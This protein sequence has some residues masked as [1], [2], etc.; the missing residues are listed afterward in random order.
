LELDSSITHSS[1]N[2]RRDVNILV[3]NQ[4]GETMQVWS[5]L[6]AVPVG[7]KTPSLKADSNTVALEELVLAYEGLRVKA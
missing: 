4:A 6:G 1:K 3:F 2:R 7:W 5:L